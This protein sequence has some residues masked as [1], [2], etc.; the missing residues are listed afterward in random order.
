MDLCIGEVGLDWEVALRMTWGNLWRAI[1]GY[2]IRQER[3]WDRTRTVTAMLYNLNRSKRQPYK[4]PHR[5][6]PLAIDKIGKRKFEWDEEKYQ[7]FEKALD[8]WGL[9]K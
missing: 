7:K 8:A 9:R 5:I 2:W 6:M 3:E 4:P 1:T